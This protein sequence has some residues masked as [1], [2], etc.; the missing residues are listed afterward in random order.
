MPLVHGRA[1]T[2]SPYLTPGRSTW[3][4]A[5]TSSE[6]R[7]CGACRRK[8]PL[9]W[10]GEARL[11]R[12]CQTAVASVVPF[13][14]PPPFPSCHHASSAA[15]WQGSS[16]AYTVGIF[17]ADQTAFA[18]PAL[19]DEEAAAAVGQALVRPACYQQSRTCHSIIEGKP[20]RFFDRPLPS[21]PL[22]CSSEQVGTFVHVYVE[23]STGRPTPM[24]PHVRAALAPLIAPH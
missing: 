11:P 24:P 14:A 6:V 21:R 7:R 16:A 10:A 22:L 15:L 13:F 5:S 12:R 2:S 18:V 20:A 17:P 8:A 1:G 19:E 23:R 3:G 9:F 4:S